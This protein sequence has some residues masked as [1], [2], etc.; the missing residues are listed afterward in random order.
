MA[1][2]FDISETMAGTHHFVDAA[3]E[4]GKDRE[5]YFRI[6]WGAPIASFVTSRVKTSDADG[7][8]FVG[9]LTDGEVP[10]R[11]TLSLD[12]VD[13]K[14][15]AYE[16]DF[17]VAGAPYHLSAA[18]VGVELARPLELAKT[19]TTAYGVVTDAKGTIVSRSILHF[20]PENLFR[21]ARSL[22]LRRD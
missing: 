5:M 17:E 4:P 8:I 19:H 9:G 6:R 12:Y 22:R 21:F 2:R 14:K 15:L 10:C 3:R 1:L 7:T 20:D 11:G 16:L 13:E 18:K